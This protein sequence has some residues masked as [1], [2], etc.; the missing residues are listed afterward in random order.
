MCADARNHKEILFDGFP[1][2]QFSLLSL[3]HLQSFFR[4][5]P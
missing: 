4:E 2:S 5:A 1:D 3:Q